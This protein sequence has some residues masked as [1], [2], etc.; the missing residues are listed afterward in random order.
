MNMCKNKWFVYDLKRQNVRLFI[1]WVVYVW[2]LMN[3]FLSCLNIIQNEI[4]TS[5]CYFALN[6]L[7]FFVAFLFC[8]LIVLYYL[9]SHC[10]ILSKEKKQ[11]NKPKTHLNIFCFLFLF[12]NLYKG[13]LMNAS[14]FKKKEKGGEWIRLCLFFSLDLWMKK[15]NNK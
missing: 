11:N 13:K 15:K 12:W 9:F 7:L 8:C 3:P 14:F 6:C 5:N 4:L 2:P 10:S 1:Y